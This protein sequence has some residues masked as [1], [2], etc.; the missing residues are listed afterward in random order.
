MAF[1]LARPIWPA[2]L[3]T[4]M[5]ITGGF[6]ARFD[7]VSA[8][9]ARC[10]VRITA[11][12][13]YRVYVN[14]RFLGHGPAAGP[15]GYYRVDEWQVPSESLRE[16]GGNIVA[17][18]VAG[19]NVNSFYTLDQPSFVQA[20][21]ELNGR[22]AAATGV[23]GDSSCAG[24]E[25]F[26][27]RER[28]RK[29]QRYSFQRPFIEA[30]SLRPDVHAWRTDADAFPA[31]PAE[32]QA[33]EEKLL[34]PRRASYPA[35]DEVSP[36]AVVA[37]G[38][39]AK[40]EAAAAP[41]RDRAMLD[42]G[43]ELKG[44]PL[45]ELSLLPTDE[46]GELTT[47]WQRYDEDEH[48]NADRAYAGQP[49]YL[50]ERAASIFGFDRNRSGFLGLRFTCKSASRIALT[51]DEIMTDRDVDHTRLECSNIIYLDCEPGSYAF[52]SIEPYTMKVMKLIV[53]EGGCELTACW[54]R[55]YANPDS[56]SAAFDSS[57]AELNAI[58]EAARESFRQNAVD[59]FMDCPSRERAGW[60]CDSFFTARVEA[61]LTGGSV[62]EQNFFENF[63]LPK[64]FAHL[65]EGMLPMCYPAD[66]YGGTF[67][68]NWALW[69][70]LQLEEYRYRGGDE[71]LI[72]AL[73]PKVDALLRYFEGFR[74]EFGLLENLES[75]VFIEWSKANSFV[76]GI[77][78]PT[79]MLYAG[80]LE[81]AGRLYDRPDY[82]EQAV[83]LK[84]I[85]R[86]FSFDGE[87]FVDQ[88]IENA[89]GE[90]ELTDHRTE[91]CQYYAAF[92]GI[93]DTQEQRNW[94]ASLL[95][96]FSPGRGS[97]EP[98]IADISGVHPA[99]AFIGYYLRM[100]L[101]SQAGA[102]AQLLQEIAA[103]FGGMAKR[104][105]TLWEHNRTTASCNHGFASHVVR[106]LYRDALGI[107]SLDLNN[108]RLTISFTDTDLQRCS[109]KLPTPFGPV[110]LAWQVQGD[111]LHYT[112]TAPPQLTVDIRNY[113]G[114]QL[115]AEMN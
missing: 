50:G 85:V 5:N 63:A 58:F 64:R 109:G 7:T 53:L 73:E 65:P 26:V 61:D 9:D 60:L 78:F 21:I 93:A 56:D 70:I 72:A 44:F 39:V 115:A 29:V 84:Q 38:T 71:T 33:A 80:A 101:L 89:D 42:I 25:A 27:L 67:I 99:N 95:H 23:T 49:M 54:L 83:A 17:V 55:E 98:T 94:F 15:H 112:L 81:A 34:L 35:F 107:E 66:H 22:V 30:Y 18:E 105:G 14:G 31:D 4:E 3:E 12:C 97:D 74:N 79:N 90:I 104:T 114:K 32:W 86:E 20:E 45:E 108:N 68:P 13:R 2:G 106:C 52:E 46:L 75:W 88:A 59:N 8:A 40:S 43:P 41:W 69:F 51:F 24:F 1:Q 19:Y 16:D 28:V 113:S 62:I 47:A 77:N 82:A 11:S 110:E 103:F 87:F 91:V 10:L 100:E 57:D 37:E 6:R 92:F 111:E 102:S 48:A 36:V 76:N 96:D